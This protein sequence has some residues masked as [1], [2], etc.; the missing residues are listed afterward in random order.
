MRIKCAQAIS[1]GVLDYVSLH[2]IDLAG[3]DI[4]K[5]ESSLKM[6]FDL[7]TQ[8]HANLDKYIKPLFPP[9]YQINQAIKDIYV[10]TICAHFKQNHFPHLD[11]YMQSQPQIL[12]E[13]FHFIRE[14]TENAKMLNEPN[15]LE[16]RA[17]YVSLGPYFP[18]FLDFS[19]NEF[20]QRWFK[21][22]NKAQRD[23]EGELIEA[24]ERWRVQEQRRAAQ[25]NE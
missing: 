10:S 3:Q 15:N 19:Q 16:F 7:F 8:L 25:A 13:A 24:S 11:S 21:N 23:E 4:Q 20:E 14:V 9:Y 1:Q 5:F 22:I 17:L 18:Q 6:G 12:L 2:L